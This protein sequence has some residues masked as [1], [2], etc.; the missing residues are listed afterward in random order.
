MQPGN[1]E[2]TICEDDGFAEQADKVQSTAPL[3]K[4]NSPF[5][6]DRKRR[7]S[8]SS[9]DTDYESPYEESEENRATTITPEKMQA[10]PSKPVKLLCFIFMASFYC[11]ML[12]Y[13]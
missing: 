1:I 6:T 12:L 3:A 2:N 8:G 11:N 7:I 5:K 4:S 10:S 9:D 13:I